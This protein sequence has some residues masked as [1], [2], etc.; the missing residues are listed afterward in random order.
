MESLWSHIYFH[1]MV[2]GSG[3]SAAVIV[4]HAVN[5]FPTPRNRYGAWLLGVIQFAVGQRVAAMNTLNGL[6][7]VVT[8][9]PTEQQKPKA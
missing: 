7:S 2:F 8:A 6:Q 4:A 3:L 1:A 5:T 9:A